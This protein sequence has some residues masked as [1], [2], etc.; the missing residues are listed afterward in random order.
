MDRREGEE[1]EK[2]S[3]CH[4]RTMRLEKALAARGADP[5]TGQAKIDVMNCV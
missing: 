4:T 3:E 5:S 2:T 1:L